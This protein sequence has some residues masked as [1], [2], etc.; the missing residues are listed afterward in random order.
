MKILIVDDEPGLAA[1]LAGWLQETGWETPG[2]ATTSDEAVEWINRNGRVDVLVCDVALEPADGFTLRETIQPHLP[3]MRT[4]FISGYDLSDYGARM[5]GCR[6]LQK[7]VS[8]PTLDEAIRSLFEITA[9]PRPVAARLPPS[10]ASR[11]AAPG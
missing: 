1:G 9:S 3:K 11:S 2:V 5:E 10:A 6:F 4:I 8:G 7:P